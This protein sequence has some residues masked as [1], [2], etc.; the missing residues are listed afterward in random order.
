MLYALF[1]CVVSVRCFCALFQLS[2]APIL[3]PDFYRHH[4][5]FIYHFIYYIVIFSIYIVIVHLLFTR[6]GFNQGA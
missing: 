4:G 3:I 5:N 6:E 2:I 1:L